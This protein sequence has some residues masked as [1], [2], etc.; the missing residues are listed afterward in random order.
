M[1]SND[2]YIIN[3]DRIALVLS[4]KSSST[5]R[6]IYNIILLKTNEVVGTIGFDPEM[7]NEVMYSVFPQY[8]KMHIATDALGLLKR[9]MYN[10]Y[11][12][13]LL[14]LYIVA[15]NKASSKVA[16]NN[17]GILIPSWEDYPDYCFRAKHYKIRVKPE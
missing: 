10:I 9:L 6:K 12:D 3:D 8:Q 11:Q 14:E 17:G 2:A 5:M 15:V 1:E 13:D 4:H 7:N 16:L